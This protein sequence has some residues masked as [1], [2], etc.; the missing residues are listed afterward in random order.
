MTVFV[1]DVTGAPIPDA[2]VVAL[3][4]QPREG[5]TTREGSVR[6]QGLRAGTYRL[7]LEAEGFV[8]LEHDVVVKAGAN[9]AE[10]TLNRAPEPPKPVEPPPA[11]K[12]EVTAEAL[13]HPL[14]PADPNA[15]ADVLSVVDW[16]SK[17]ALKRGEG[18]KEAVV[19]RSAGLA[20]AVLQVRDALYDRAHPDADEL[21]YVINGK[22]VFS[23]KGR[24]QS[25]DTGALLLVPHGV[26]YTL[27]NRGREP[28]WAISI[29]SP[30]D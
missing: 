15:A 30:G 28:L 3:G 2:R 26:T 29:L 4:S 16:L 19:T 7:H 10:V 25:L 11:P 6:L 18:R 14:P 23:S 22:A 8:T 17:N 1:T 27:E 13:G 24:Q 5:R 9:E 12:P 20:G 21:I